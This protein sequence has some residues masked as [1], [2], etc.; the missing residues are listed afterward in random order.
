LANPSETLR[1]GDADTAGHSTS[2]DEVVL[3]HWLLARC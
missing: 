2:I 3:V 1:H